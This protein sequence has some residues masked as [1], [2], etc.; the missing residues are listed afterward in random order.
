MMRTIIQLVVLLL[1]LSQSLPLY[2]TGVEATY[3]LKVTVIQNPTPFNTTGVVEVVVSWS[4][5]PQN[6]TA[7][8]M[9]GGESIPINITSGNG[10]TSLVVAIHN[11]TSES[12]VPREVRLVSS[13]GGVL[14]RSPTGLRFVKPKIHLSLRTVESCY[15]SVLQIAVSWRDVHG[16]ERLTLRCGGEEIYSEEVSGSGTRLVNVFFSS[17]TTITIEA[18]LGNLTSVVKT[19]EIRVYKPEIRITVVKPEEKQESQQAQQSQQQPQTPQMPTLPYLGEVLNSPLA[20]A[21]LV[22][23]VIALAVMLFSSRRKY[24]QPPPQPYPQY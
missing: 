8:L 10:T 20:I 24:Y 13:L 9:I 15:I 2:S 21:G 6:I 12:K 11:I 3:S 4:N 17:N 5:V 14:A 22:L 7:K 19:A 18:S 1:V 23:I 16:R